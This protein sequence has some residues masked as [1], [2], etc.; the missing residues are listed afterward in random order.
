[1]RW[2]RGRIG[3]GK[4]HLFA[5]LIENAHTRNWVTSYVQISGR[6]YGVELHRF[7]QVYAAIVRNCLCRE[8][9]A[10][11]SGRIEPGRVPGWHWILKSW[12]AALTLQVTRRDQADVPTLRL[13]EVLER[14]ITSMRRR[15]SVH[16][17][18]A[19]ALQQ[20]ARA[21][22]DGDA[23]WSTVLLNWFQGVD[24]HAQG[25][26][27]RARLRDAGISESVTGTMLVRCCGVFL[28]S[29]RPWVRRHS[30][31]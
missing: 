13:Y 11:E 6:G 29:C 26:E 12:W 9:V 4:T 20:Y 18:F 7:E 8:L 23:T 21:E 14:A 15:W 1:M 3:Q 2:V 17:A 19:A 28:R 30:G 27:V 5:R 22:M 25:G 16:S 24:V 31:Y 10:E